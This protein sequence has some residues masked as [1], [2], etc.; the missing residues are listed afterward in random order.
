MTLPFSNSRLSDLSIHPDLLAPDLLAAGPANPAAAPAPP[1]PAPAAVRALLD[2][3]AVFP[4][5]AD[6]YAVLGNAGGLDITQ[7]PPLTAAELRGAVWGGIRSG[8]LQDRGAVLYLGGGT[9][10]EPSAT[11]V[12]TGLF[13]EAIR[14]VWSPLE[15][16]DVLLNLARGTR[17][18]PV[19]DLVEAL[20]EATGCSTIPYGRPEGGD[21]APW[22][23]FFAQCGATAL[24]ADTSTL[25]ELLQFCRQ[26]G[27]SLGWARTLVWVGAGLDRA[28]AELIEQVLPEARVFGL[29]GSV[30]SWVVGSSGPQCPRDVYHVL[31]HQYVEL[32]DGEI[33]VTT[34]HESAISPLI[35]YRTGDLGEF[36]RCPCGDPRPALRLLG[37]IDD[38]LSFRGARFGRAELADLARGVAEVDEADVTVLDGGLPTER[39]QLRIRA[40]DGEIADRYLEEWV[41]EHLLT[42]HVTLSQVTAG[43]PD[44]V[45]VVAE[46]ADCWSAP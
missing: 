30:E 36:T 17:L 13:A 20:A 45:E 25:R 16:T 4:G 37:R 19:H 31:P 9:A 14:Q 44:A 10:A 23:D 5:L 26:S 3:A 27:R 29:Y 1:K 6:R 38:V 18:W 41:L 8:L 2:R 32:L 7:V 22:V 11:V 35:R 12:P 28:T 40:A 21:L 24:A 15:R 34:L 39:L 33:L 42:S 46:G 43:V